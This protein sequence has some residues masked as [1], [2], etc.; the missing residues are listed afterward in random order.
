MPHPAGC[1]Q[2]LPVFA[3]TV[4]MLTCVCT[5]APWTSGGHDYLAHLGSFL[6]IDA[7]EQSRV[8]SLPASLG[9]LDREHA[10]PT[11]YRSS[12]LHYDQNRN[13]SIVATHEH[14]R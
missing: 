4:I 7:S 1:E 11:S 3:H 10:T 5:S 13:S 6:E 14:S 12:I 2:L 9:A 8:L